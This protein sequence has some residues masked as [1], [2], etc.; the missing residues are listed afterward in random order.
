MPERCIQ[1]NQKHCQI[2]TSFLSSSFFC[3]FSNIALYSDLLSP[4]RSFS[5]F[6][7]LPLYFTFFSVRISKTKT[8]SYSFFP[9]SLFSTLTESRY[10]SSMVPAIHL[11]EKDTLH[12]SNRLLLFL[13]L[14]KPFDVQN[15]HENLPHSS[16][17][18][19]SD[20]F[21]VNR[22]KNSKNQ[23]HYELSQ[24]F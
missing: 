2:I 11:V 6:P 21:E 9:F 24:V 16:F 8:N 10:L 5:I 22:R 18:I 13:L 12:L 1:P 23:Q 15:L 3:L 4:F 20:C 17:D 14:F 19:V 7:L